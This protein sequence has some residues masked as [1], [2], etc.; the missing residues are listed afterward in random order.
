MT[1]TAAYGHKYAV[2]GPKYAV[3]GP[4]YAVYGPEYRIYVPFL[5]VYRIRRPY[6]AFHFYP[7]IR[8]YTVYPYTAYTARANPNPD[9][10]DSAVSLT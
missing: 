8:I 3:Y 10:M 4:E 7:Y 9:C 5:S 2:Y 6:M 1:R